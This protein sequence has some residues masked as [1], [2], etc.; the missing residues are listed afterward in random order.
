VP[1]AKQV[2]ILKAVVDHPR[3]AVRSGHKVGKSRCAAILAH[4]WVSTRPGAWVIMTSSSGRQ[5]KSILWAEFRKL[6]THAPFCLGPLPAL[7]PNAGYELL[8]GRRVQ[9]FSTDTPERMAGI[10]GENVLFILDEASGIP[11][12]IFEAIEGNRAGG[13]RCVMFSNPTQTSG[14]FYDAFHTK[15]NFWHGIVLSSEDSPNVKAGRIVISGLATA[16][17]IDEKKKEWGED[18]PIFQVRVRGNFPSQAD[19]AVIGLSLVEAAASPRRFEITLVEGQLH[20]GVDPA[21]FGD[22]ESCIVARRGN[23]VLG[24][25]SYQNLDGVQLA[26]KVLEHL[27]KLHQKGDPLPRVKIDTIG[28]GASC[29]DQL[30]YARSDEGRPLLE[31]VEVVSSEKALDESLY[32]NLRDQLWFAIRDWLVTGYL[33]ADDKLHGELVAPRYFFDARGRYQ[34]E[35]KDQLRARLGRSPDRADALALAIF[36]GFSSLYVPQDDT[37]V[38]DDDGYHFSHDQR[39]FG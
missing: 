26:G 2:D 14:T 27:R 37:P 15:K 16:A 20:L 31:L 21:R 23:R 10:S 11:E 7:D 24:I 39:G 30:R 8:D 22:D 4:W 38:D 18:S 5:V 34:V 28:L 32:R 33:P 17:W 35:S 29:A 25:W 19:D 6:Y 9:G 36:E 13:A 12:P 3:V 1:W